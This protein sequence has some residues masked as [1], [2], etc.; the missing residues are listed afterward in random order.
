FIDTMSILRWNP[1]AITIAGSTGQK[2]NASNLLNV[3]FG[4]TLDS[5]TTLYI[6]DGFNNRVQKYL[7]DESFGVTV[8]GQVDGSSNSTSSYLNFPSDVAV[9]S[10]G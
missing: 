8:A 10:D 4:L 7:R 3:P 5:S 9:D 2:G 1:S 6:A